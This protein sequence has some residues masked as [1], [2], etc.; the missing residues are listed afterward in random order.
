MTLRLWS[1]LLCKTKKNIKYQIVIVC[2][3]IPLSTLN[4]P[5]FSFR[6]TYRVFK[7][8][9]ETLVETQSKLRA[10]WQVSYHT[11]KETGNC[12]MS[13]LSYKFL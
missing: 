3:C 9:T 12:I 1:I 7:L 6:V 13:L 5:N 2:M 10:F 8:N 11:E 4:N